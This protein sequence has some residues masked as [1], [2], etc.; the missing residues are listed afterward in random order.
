MPM[1]INEFA[2]EYDFVERHHINVEATA[3]RVYAAVRVLDLSRAPLVR[4]L[5]KLRGMPP[6]C[7]TLDGLLKAGFVLLAEV[8]NEELVL[9]VAG[10]FWSLAGALQRLDAESFRSFQRS[11]YAKAVWN[12]SLEPRGAHAVRLTTETRVRCMDA[13]SRRAFG[14]YWFFIRPC[15]GLVRME[16]LRAIK[17]AAEEPAPPRV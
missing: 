10:R 8:P 5:F 11:G 9:G 15:S 13:A 3:E 1:Q 12:F 14:F 7:L 4:A 17:R 16:A 2:P 6:Q